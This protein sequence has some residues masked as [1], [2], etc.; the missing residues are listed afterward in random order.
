MSAIRYGEITPDPPQPPQQPMR[1]PPV[2][3][4]R[5]SRDPW[6]KVSEIAIELGVS[7][8]TVYRLLHDAHIESVRVGR[9]LRVRK[10]WVMDY[11]KRGG[12]EWVER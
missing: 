6:M 7:K 9:G 10:S 1:R 3:P 4:I 2:S 11:I 12:N 5:P 8:M